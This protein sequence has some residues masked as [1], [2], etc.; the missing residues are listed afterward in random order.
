MKNRYWN[1]EKVIEIKNGE[2]K[3]AVYGYSTDTNGVEVDYF[4]G[5]THIDTDDLTRTFLGDKEARPRDNYVIKESDVFEIVR[6]N[7]V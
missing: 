2:A 5:V 7:E 3:C 6:K 4:E 1:F